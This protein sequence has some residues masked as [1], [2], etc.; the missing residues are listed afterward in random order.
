M[1]RRQPKGRRAKSGQWAKRTPCPVKLGKVVEHQIEAMRVH[2]LAA[3]M[4]R[5][6][7]R[8]RGYGPV[9]F[10]RPPEP[11]PDWR[12]RVVIDEHAGPIDPALLDVLS[13]LNPKVTSGK[14]I[15][16]TTNDRSDKP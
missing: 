8:E 10:T 16:A 1:T 6:I 13:R 15:E 2:R 12:E 5:E 14:V 7:A 3:A 4:L 11:V 9:K